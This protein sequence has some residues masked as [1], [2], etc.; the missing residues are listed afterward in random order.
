MRL[1]QLLHLLRRPEVQQQLH[2]QLAAIEIGET[3]AAAV[4]AQLLQ[5]AWTS[6]H[7]SFRRL[8]TAALAPYAA[9]PRG[10]VALSE[11][12]APR[13]DPAALHAAFQRRRP[14]L[15]PA[16]ERRV[17]LYFENFC[18]NHW[19]KDW[20][21]RSPGL[22]A[23][24]LLLLVRVATLQFLLR[25]HPGLPAAVAAPPEAQ[26]QALDALAV[27]VFY[28]LSRV[29]DHHGKLMKAVEESLIEQG[30]LTLPHAV[31]L[32]KF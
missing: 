32:L 21:L 27:Q 30:M 25:S 10:G 11:G 7:R 14:P 29:T 1:Y 4:V 28:T 6:G 24:V 9:D 19:V 26:A 15:P 18:R 3:F 2:D 16:L 31:C 5:V 13:I 8:L 12:G 23:H 22:L 17:D 20:Y